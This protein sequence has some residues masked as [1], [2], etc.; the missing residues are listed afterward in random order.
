MAFTKSMFKRKKGCQATLHDAIF[1]DYRKHQKIVC[2]FKKLSAMCF[3]IAIFQ[4]RS[5]ELFPAKYQG[6]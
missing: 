4:K 1:E 3:A 2:V 6:H 5:V